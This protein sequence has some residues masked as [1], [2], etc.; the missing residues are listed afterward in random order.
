MALLLFGVQ[1]EKL[2]KLT[3]Q[4]IMFLKL[5]GERKAMKIYN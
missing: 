1:D 3:N 4:I 2:M 5:F